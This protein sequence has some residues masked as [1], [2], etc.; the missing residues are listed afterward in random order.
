MFE[1]IT[2]LYKKTGNAEVVEK[3]ATKGWISQEERKSILAG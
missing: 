3:A 1:T 2:R